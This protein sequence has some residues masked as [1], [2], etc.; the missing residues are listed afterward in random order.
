MCGRYGI[1]LTNQEAARRL[2]VDFNK[3][4]ADEPGTR[5]NVPPG[6]WQPIAIGQR[7]DPSIIEIDNTYWG[8][9]PSWQ[10]VVGKNSINMRLESAAKPYWSKA[11]RLRRCVIPAAWYDE[12]Q[13]FPAGQKGKQPHVIRPQETDG[14]FFAGVWSVA[15]AVQEHRV[16]GQRTFAILTQPAAGEIEHI[17]HRMPV[18]LDDEGARRWLEPGDDID[19]LRE[20]ISQHTYQHYCS[21][22]VTYR[23]ND[24]RN[25]DASILD[26]LQ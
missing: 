24:V 20:I 18:S 26:P 7:Q 10:H 21:Y 13:P 1:T 9:L 23:V 17:H 5:Y 25:T 19:L 12:W 6:T 8:F 16:A 15:K 22:A 14:F 2:G 11:L 4:L 3:I